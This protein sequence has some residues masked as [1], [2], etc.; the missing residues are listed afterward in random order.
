MS[1]E[2]QTVSFNKTYQINTAYTERYQASIKSESNFFLL[3][4]QFIQSQ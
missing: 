1:S 2:Q 3:V 4:Y